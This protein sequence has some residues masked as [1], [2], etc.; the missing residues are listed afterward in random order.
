MFDKVPITIEGESAWGMTKM[1]FV[2]VDGLTGEEFG[3][4]EPV[5]AV[6]L[7]AASSRVRAS[8]AI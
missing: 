8:G 3:L 6:Q 5:G 4:F 1:R 7:Q 2:V